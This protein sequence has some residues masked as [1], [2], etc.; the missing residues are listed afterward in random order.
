MLIARD[1][2][3][4]ACPSRRLLVVLRQGSR[5][6]LFRQGSA[7][8]YPG[9]RRGSRSCY[10]D[11]LGNGLGFELNGDLDTLFG[12]YYGGFLLE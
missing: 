5:A 6:A 10:E 4:T 1:K 7:R 3:K 11:V 9:L 2:A 8:V 12:Y